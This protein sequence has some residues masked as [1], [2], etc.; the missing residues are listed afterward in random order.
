MTVIETISYSTPLWTVQVVKPQ[1]WHQLSHA[2]FALYDRNDPSHFR[3]WLFF[4]TFTTTPNQ[5]LSKRQGYHV[6]STRNKQTQP[7]NMPV[8][9]LGLAAVAAGGGAGYFVMRRRRNQQEDAGEEKDHDEVVDFSGE[10]EGSVKKNRFSFGRKSTN[11]KDDKNK[12]KEEKKNKWNMPKMPTKNSVSMM[13][14]KNGGVG[15][16]AKMAMKG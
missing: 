4:L 8:V 11:D 12:K 5:F 16:M 13:M 1:S 3:F 9:V 10:Q 6:H 2:V 7:V 15:A 14:M